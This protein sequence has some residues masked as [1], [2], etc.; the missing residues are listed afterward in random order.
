MNRDVWGFF[1]DA[2][3]EKIR[4]VI[5]GEIT[6]DLKISYLRRMFD[7]EGTG[8]RAKLHDCSQFEYCEFGQQPTSDFRTIEA[9]ETWILYVH[10]TDPLVLDCTTGT[11]TLEYQS[12]EISLDSGESVTYEALREAC[13]RYWDD[14][15]GKT[16][17]SNGAA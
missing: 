7:G 14:W 3:I 17:T 5:P 11:L 9:S 13:E 15:S 4:G 6:L 16:P 8:F 10:S 2:E 1:H 12:M